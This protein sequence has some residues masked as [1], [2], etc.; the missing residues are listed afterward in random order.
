MDH[1]YPHVARLVAETPWAIIPERLT[2]IVEMLAVRAEGGRFSEDELA[3]RIGAGPAAKRPYSQGAVAVIPVYGVLAPRAN[4]LVQSSGGTSL[5]GLQTAIAEA[6]SDPQVDAIMLEIDS[7]GGSTDLVAETA[8]MV[9]QAR[10]RKPVWAV[11]NTLAASAAYWI[12]SQADE[13]VVT[14]S[15]EVGSIGVFAAHQ[16]ISGMQEMAGIRTTI[17]RAGRHKADLHPFAP[18]SDEARAALQGRVDEFHAMFTRDVAR[19][20]RVSVATVR[21]G[22]GQGRVVTASQAVAEGMVDRVET[23]EQALDRLARGPARRQ[24]SSGASLSV[25]TTSTASANRPAPVSTFS[26]V[27]AAAHDAVVGVLDHA[28]SLAE[29]GRGRLTATKRETLADV[30][31]QL[32]HV[33]GEIREMLAATDPDRHVEYL[34]SLRAAL[35]RARHEERERRWTS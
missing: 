18:L 12:G 22:F 31:M 9:R 1:R 21:E 34:A 35:E 28:R 15:G 24:A 2:A 29:F 6:V 3:A 33:A 13:L 25:T 26:E 11:A 19:G 4:M 10:Q 8:Q 23:F 27:A 17:V 32:D 16:D 14:P 5:T 7:P 20:R 30:L